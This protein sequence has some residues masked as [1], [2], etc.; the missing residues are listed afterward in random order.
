MVANAA[1]VVYLR[2]TVGWTTPTY[3]SHEFECEINSQS[4]L[5]VVCL[6][7]RTLLFEKRLNW[8]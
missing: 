8:F 3:F 7:I 4:K 2:Q 6:I 1:A 5:E